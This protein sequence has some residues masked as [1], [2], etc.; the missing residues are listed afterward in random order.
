[1]GLLDSVEGLINNTG[2]TGIQKFFKT[3]KQPAPQVNFFTSQG[4]PQ[5]TENRVRIMVPRSY[6]SNQYTN[7][8]SSISG[9]NAVIF[10][11]TPQIQFEHKAD[12]SSGNIMHSNFQQNFYQRSSIG[13]ITVTGKWTVQN[14]TEAEVYL[15]TIHLLRALTKMQTANDKI[16][17]SP[18][19]V[20]RL[21]AY[22]DYMLNNVPVA[23]TGFRSDLPENVDYFSLPINGIFKGTAV[24]VVSTIS[25]NLIPMYSREEQQQFSVTGWLGGGLNSKGYL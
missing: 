10:P 15:S 5:T 6:V 12:Y 4:A 14:N 22:G 17:G 20:C 7:K 3:G 18:P 1:M 11:Y 24:P 2:L 16:P 8:E 21:F 13:A 19:P 25:I 9:K 23:I